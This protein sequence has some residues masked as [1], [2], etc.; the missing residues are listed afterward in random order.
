MRKRPERIKRLPDEYY[1]GFLEKMDPR[2]TLS[3]RLNAWF[4]ETIEAAG[5][6]DAM[7]PP[8]IALIEQFTFLREFLVEIALRM[9]E[10]KNDWKEYDALFGKWVQGMNAMSG[11]ATKIGLKPVERELPDLQSILQPEIERRGGRDIPGSNG[12]KRKKAKSE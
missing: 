11:L 9:R 7:T 4:E 1:K 8:M 2:T 10:V 6:M 5:G 3:K 12:K